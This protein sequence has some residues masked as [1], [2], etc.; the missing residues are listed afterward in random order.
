MLSAGF[1]SAI[2]LVG[3]ES[4]KALK[5]AV[6]SGVA[7]I[8]RMLSKKKGGALAWVDEHIGDYG[9]RRDHIHLAGHSS[10]AHMAALLTV[11]THYLAAEGK[12]ARA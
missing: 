10:G 5:G 11:D 6:N 8:E 2:F 9:G 3:Y 1:V 7:M 4:H 12:D